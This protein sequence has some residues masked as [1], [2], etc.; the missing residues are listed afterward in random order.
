M[1]NNQILCQ[2][3]QCTLDRTYSTVIAKYSEEE[4]NDNK[5][6]I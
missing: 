2:I 3:V 5:A 6:L 1:A 4:S